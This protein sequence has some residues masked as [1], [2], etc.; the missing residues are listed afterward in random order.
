MTSSDFSDCVT[1]HFTLRLIA[2]LTALVDFRQ[3]EI[4]LVS[5]SAVIA[6]RSPYAVE[7]IEAAIQNLPL[8]RG[9]HQKVSGS[10][11]PLPYVDAAGFP[12][13]YGLPSC[14]SFSEA[15]SAFTHPVT[16][17]HEELATWLS[18]DYHDRTSTG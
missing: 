17:E 1:L 14:T 3:S 12:S 8:V 9:L 4:S 18:G 16:Q 7:S 15:Y 13:W 6:F 2:G 10:A 11:L 5:A